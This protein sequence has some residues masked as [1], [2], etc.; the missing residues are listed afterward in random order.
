MLPS[1]STLKS[2]PTPSRPMRQTRARSKL[3]NAPP[4]M[5]GLDR[6]GLAQ[7]P[8]S[9]DPEALVYDDVVKKLIGSPKSAL[10]KADDRWR[11]KTKVTFRSYPS[12]A[13]TPIRSP[14]EDDGDASQKEDDKSGN[15]TDDPSNAPP[16]QSSDDQALGEED[17]VISDGPGSPDSDPSGPPSPP[18]NPGDDDNHGSSDDSSSSSDSSESLSSSGDDDSPNSPDFTG[19]PASNRSI[20]QESTNN[21]DGQDSHS[22]NSDTSDV[23]TPPFE[24]NQY[25]TSFTPTNPPS[26]SDSSR[27]APRLE[28][29][30]HTQ[31]SST[32]QIDVVA[33][34]TLVATSPVSA[35]DQEE[36]EEEDDE[37]EE[38]STQNTEL[39]K[40][41]LN[42]SCSDGSSKRSRQSD[43]DDDDDTPPTKRQ[44][45]P[46]TT[47]N[48]SAA[49]TRAT[50]PQDSSVS[51]ANSHNSGG[52]SPSNALTEEVTNTASS[53]S[54]S[55]Y[56]GNFS[57]LLIPSLDPEIPGLYSSS[58]RARPHYD[59]YEQYHD[60][61][62]DCAKVHGC[63][64]NPGRMCHSCH[65]N[66]LKAWSLYFEAHKLLDEAAAN[67]QK[68]LEETGLD[69]RQDFMGY[70]MQ[71]SGWQVLA[72]ELQ[73]PVANSIRLHPTRIAKHRLAF[74]QMAIA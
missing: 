1:N 31:G 40:A 59:W 25:N 38:G 30:D 39:I 14:V 66:W 65:A 52:G 33:P 29:P 47:S 37:K 48:T 34:S 53:E 64:H 10:K 4:L 17:S 68:Y 43:D 70:L 54:D 73:P 20:D 57:P 45:L 19:P 3:S 55:Q 41:S 72:P 16:D 23:S 56:P 42:N 60:P 12:H 58:I 13:E 24:N 11:R 32:S 8:L 18:Q 15:D 7:D 9:A 61:G 2:K 51:A 71:G 62:L 46:S 21:D 69:I 28:S 6:R 74:A 27:L 49:A 50:V 35:S 26:N 67:P 63:A 36:D 22:S 5:Q 44:M